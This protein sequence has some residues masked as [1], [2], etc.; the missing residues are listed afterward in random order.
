MR[1]PLAAVR[2]YAQLARRQIEHGE[3]DLARLD[4]WLAEIDG[5]VGR[6]DTLVGELMDASLIHGGREVPLKSATTDLGEIGGELIE[7][8]RAL[9][10]RHQFVLDVPE[11]GPIGLWDPARVARVL[12]NL[13]DNAVKYS[14]DGG[15]IRLSIGAEGDVA[16]ASVI[17]HGIGIP[18]SER[19]LIFSARYRGLNS[20][21]IKGTGI[22]LAG[23]RRLMEQMGG[24]LTV[25][26]RVGEGS[27]FT[28][29]LPL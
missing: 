10:E 6:L 17:D 8:Q 21:G 4:G 24:M 26:S 9:S 22:G 20:G 5:V 27:T 14:P 11:E 15:E 25:E 3:P 13:L 29:R 7:R 2:G 16:V 18:L 28:V 1:T 23:S 12:E 19:D